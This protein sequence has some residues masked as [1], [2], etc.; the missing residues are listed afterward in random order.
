MESGLGGQPAAARRTA[1]IVGVGN[2]GGGMAARLL[3]RGWRVR[4]CDLVPAKVRA[5]AALG[6][7]AAASPAEAAR[8]A[9]VLIVCVV[10][11]TQ[12]GQVLFDAGGAAAVLA[13]GVAVLLCP[14]IAPEDVERLAARLADQGLAAID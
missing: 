4:A 10:D 5:L 14:T 7:E 1:G 9:D 8:G 13:S 11:A 12:A 2:M 6:A 3:E